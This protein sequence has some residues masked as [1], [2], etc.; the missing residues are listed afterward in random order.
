M[1]C[2][3][4]WLPARPPVWADGAP[5]DTQ[6]VAVLRDHAVKSEGPLPL[7]IDQSISSGTH[8]RKHQ[9]HF[10]FFGHRKRVAERVGAWQQPRKKS[11]AWRTV[12]LGH[13]AAISG[14]HVSMLIFAAHTTSMDRHAYGLASGRQFGGGR[15]A[16]IDRALESPRFKSKPSSHPDGANVLG[17]RPVVFPRDFGRSGLLPAHWKRPT[18]VEYWFSMF[19]C[20]HGCSWCPNCDGDPTTIGHVARHDWFW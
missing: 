11:E 20:G 15:S 6:G 13:M 14:M 4:D 16:L 9:A 3:V 10:W 7:V 5:K 12:G 2:S 18:L 8:R 17:R 19:L 1:T